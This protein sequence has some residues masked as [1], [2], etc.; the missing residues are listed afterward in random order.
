MLKLAEELSSYIR[1]KL[2]QLCA[3]KSLSS[4][5]E[6]ASNLAMPF[7][8]VMNISSLHKLI[9]SLIHIFYG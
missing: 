7:F 6:S 8:T 9:G 4:I 3:S 5:F 2:Q 1:I